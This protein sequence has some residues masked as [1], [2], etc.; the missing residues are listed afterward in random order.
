ML[1]RRIAGQSEV[2]AELSVASS[3]VELGLEA[4]PDRYEFFFADPTSPG[5]K[6]SLGA[7]PTMPLSS[8]V[9]GGFTGAYLGM[10]AVGSAGGAADF[11][12][13]EYASVP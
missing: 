13:F 1:R 4:Y 11:D 6:R 10:F 2:V 7:L 9:A 8:E 5:S 3:R 12:W